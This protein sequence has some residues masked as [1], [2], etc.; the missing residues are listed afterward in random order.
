MGGGSSGAAPALNQQQVTTDQTKGNVNAAVSQS[1]LNNVNQVTPYG[2]LNYAETGGTKDFDGN[3]IP[4]FTATQTM[5]PDQQ[6]IYN[7]QMALQGQA[8]GTAGTVLN[9]VNTAIST[10]L[11]YDGLQQI[12]DQTNFR[13]DA[14]NALEARGSRSIAQAEDAQRTAMANQGISA[15]STAYSRG[16]QDYGQ[17][18]VDNSQQALINATSLAGQNEQQQLALR[19]QGIME[20]TNLRNQPLQDYQAMM[21]FGGNVTQPNYVNTPQSQ[22]QP[23]DYTGPAIANYQGKQQQAQSAQSSQAGMTSGMMGLAGTIGMG[24]MMY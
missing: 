20:R 3:W 19:N 12:G 15:G 17:Q 22:V 21:G 9:N 2:S 10:P 16:L 13:N 5:S 6:G 7:Q 4:Q 1:R 11:N 18:R 8:L 14:Q 23:T 24:A